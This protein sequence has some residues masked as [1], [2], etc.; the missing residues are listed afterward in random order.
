MPNPDAIVSSRIR[1]DPPLDRTPAELL[2]AEGGLTVE[3]D[4]E[5]RIALDPKDPRSAGFVEILDG[6]RELRKPV[7]LE[8]DP[9][10]SAITRLV[11]PEVTYVI[12]IGSTEPGVLE[13]QLDR[14]HAVHRL[15][16]G[17]PDSADLER[18]LRDAL[19]RKRP[20]I[21]IEDDAHE[22]FDLRDFT[23]GPDD[24]PLPP[25]PEPKVPRF[26]WPKLVLDLWRLLHAIWWWPYWPW[27]WFSVVSMKHAQW[28][29]DQM[30]ATNCDPLTTPAPCIPFMFP[31][32]GCWVR[33]NE[34]CRLMGNMG[35]PTRKVW[36]TRGPTKPL[37]AVTRNHQQC[38]VE[39]YWHV[40]PTILVRGPWIFQ[41]RRMV[42]DPSL[43]TGPLTELNW[44]LLMQDAS[45]TLQDTDA[46]QYYYNSPTSSDPTY[47][48]TIAELI[49]FRL[50]LKSRSLQIGS[51]P[52]SNCP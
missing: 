44:R 4:G 16:L 33:A 5:R 3:L 22:I 26:P 28:L 6:L 30:K 32:N 18:R 35:E 38:Y 39:W 52:Y 51:P 2:E 7:Y 15:T 11:I 14:S 20:L 13:V 36:I 40:A 27:W 45:A 37:H 1:F 19:E 21:V 50:Q 41:V 31:D 34:M 23:P 49:S 25:F 29:F 48:T 24:G 43:A 12:G 42:I 9:A 46:T 47:S 10:T 17:E 8:V